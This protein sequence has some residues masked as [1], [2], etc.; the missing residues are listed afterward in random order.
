MLN[1]IRA[2]QLVD[3]DTAVTSV[4]YPD[5]DRT[6]SY[7]SYRTESRL[8]TGRFSSFAEAHRA[9]ELLEDYHSKLIKP[10]DK[11]LRLAIE[12]V[13]KIFKSR[14]FQALLG[15]SYPFKITDVSVRHKSQVCVWRGRG[16]EQ[17]SLPPRRTIRHPVA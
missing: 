9:L 16:V 12:R 4:I 8:I 10:Q 13:I 3:P 1:S 15:K 11:Q 17:I 6:K 2:R 14:L 7:Y 5:N